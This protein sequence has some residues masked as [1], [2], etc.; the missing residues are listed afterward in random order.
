MNPS[1]RFWPF[2]NETVQSVLEPHLDIFLHF[3]LV[4]EQLKIVNKI[5]RN[6]LSTWMSKMCLDTIYVWIL[7]KD[8]LLDGACPIS[9]QMNVLTHLGKTWKRVSKGSICTKFILSPNQSRRLQTGL[10]WKLQKICEILV[11]YNFDSTYYWYENCYSYFISCSRPVLLTRSSK[12]SIVSWIF[13]PMQ[14]NLTTIAD[15]W[16]FW[17]G[18]C[19]SK[20]H[21]PVTLSGNPIFTKV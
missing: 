6:C 11:D 20:A 12:Q 19:L 21:K 15:P 16:Y 9:S 14:T 1:Y 3:Y 4:H 7:T 5:E 13:L 2:C 10:N 18:I 17:K 8:H